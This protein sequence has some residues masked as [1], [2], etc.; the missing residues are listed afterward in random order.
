MRLIAAAPGHIGITSGGRT[1]AQ[2]AALYA[3][4][5]PGLAAKPGSSWHEK[6]LAADLNW[7]DQN[8][9]NWMHQH[10]AE[11]GMFFPMSYEP[12]HIQPLWTRGRSA[13]GAGGRA[14]DSM[15][16]P[17]DGTAPVATGNPDPVANVLGNIQSL[18]TAPDG[19]QDNHPL[20]Q[21]G[22]F[23]STLGD[24]SQIFQPTP[25]TDTGASGGGLAAGLGGGT[26]QQLRGGF[27]TAYNLL[28]QNGAS[29][30]EARILAAVAG[31]ESGYNAAAHN[32]NAKTGDDSYGLWQINMLGS[33]G[34][35]RRKA[36]GITDNAQL[37]D[38]NVNARAAVSILRSQGFGAWTGY[39]S[40]RYRAYLQ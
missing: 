16:T 13:S 2:Q 38:P 7:S 27:S 6:G 34:P 11:Y 40:G 15:S 33:M 37:F 21:S 4:K 26:H 39:T 17:P 8:T 31:P 10:A 3:Q 29:P 19:F 24:I 23:E 9:L 18:V 1:N 20:D 35:A 32:Q 28:I 14:Q 25:A 12:W 36:F 22:D 30:A 5:G